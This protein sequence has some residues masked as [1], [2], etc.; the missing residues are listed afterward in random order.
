MSNQGGLN[1]SKVKI[2][3]FSKKYF[4]KSLISR[5]DTRSCHRSTTSSNFMRNLTKNPSLRIKEN[6]FSTKYFPIYFKSFS[7]FLHLSIYS[8]IIVSSFTFRPKII[9][10]SDS[11]DFHGNRFFLRKL[12]FV[13]LCVLSICQ[14]TKQQKNLSSV[15]TAF[16][17]KVY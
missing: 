14:L 4:L 12:V 9:F 13:K 8:C 10:E 16:F 17:R 11:G 2:K 3:K 1:I 15:S 6:L 7:F 5:G